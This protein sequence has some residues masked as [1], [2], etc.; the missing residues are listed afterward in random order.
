MKEGYRKTEINGTPATLGKCE[1]TDHKGNR[2]IEQ[3]S[4]KKGTYKCG[5]CFFKYTPSTNLK[6][7][8]KARY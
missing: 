4:R 7:W 8:N 2:E 6:A 1:A 5:T 3:V